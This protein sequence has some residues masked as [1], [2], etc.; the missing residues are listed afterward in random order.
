MEE[1]LIECG[2]CDQQKRRDSNLSSSFLH[3][4]R[5]TFKTRC[6]E[7]WL[8]F[9]LI[10]ITIS[11]VN[12]F[13]YEGDNFRRS[14]RGTRHR[15]ST[16][17]RNF[18]NSLKRSRAEY[19]SCLQGGE[20]LKGFTLEGGTKAGNFTSLGEA[21]SLAECARICCRRPGCPQALLLTQP[22]TNSKTCFEV[23]C[24]ENK[25]CKEVSALDSA[26][27]PELFR[28]G[29]SGNHH[30]KVATSDAE[31]HSIITNQGKGF[32][33]KF[34]GSVCQNHV[35]PNQ[36]YF[37]TSTNSSKLDKR[38]EHPIK[39]L[40]TRLTGKCRTIALQAICYRFFPQCQNSSP[41]KP[42]NICED[43]CNSIL[44]GDCADAFDDAHLTKYLQRVV[45]NCLRGDDYDEDY[46]EDEDEMNDIDDTKKKCIRLVDVL[47]RANT[48]EETKDADDSETQP[49]V[50][51]PTT[52]EFVTTTAATSKLIVTTPQTTITIAPTASGKKNNDTVNSL[53]E[54]NSTVDIESETHSPNKP[55]ATIVNVTSTNENEVDLEEVS[56]FKKELTTLAPTAIKT[57]STTGL[58]KGSDEIRVSAGDNSVLTLPENKITLYSST[59]PKEKEAGAYKYRWTQIS[60]PPNS[61]GE[62]EGKSTES[63]KLT[64]LD[65]P[66]LY[67]FKLEVTSKSDGKHGVDFV[68]I[69]VKQASRKNKPPRAEI[70]PKEQQITLPTNT[71]IL[72]GSKST[73]DDEIVTYKWEELKGPIKENTLLTASDKKILELKNLVAGVYKFKL[74]VTDSSGETDSTEASVTVK[75]EQDYPPEANAGNDIVIRLPNNSVTL[76]G[77]KSKDDKGFLTYAWR[78]TAESPICDLLGT[79]KAKLQVSLMTVGTYVFVLKVTD[80]SG[81]SNE[82]QVKVVVL[83]EENTVPIAVAGD[84]KE[85]VYPDDSTTLDGSKS[86]DNSKIVSYL[87]EK[88]SGPEKIKMV[89]AGNAKVHLTDLVPGTYVMKLTVTDDK[90]LTGSD[91][92]K[93]LVKK[94][95][96]DSPVADAGKDQ[97]L[98]LPART[99]TIDGGKSHDDGLIDSYVWTRAGLSPAAGE[100]VNGSDHKSMLQ[101]TGL[102]KGQ[103]TFQLTVTDDKGLTGNDEVTLIVKENP[104]S[105]NLVEMYLDID[106]NKFTEEDKK[107]LLRKISVLMEVAQEFVVVQQISDVGYKKGVI[108]VFYV[109]D[110]NVEDRRL[111]GKYVADTLKH[112]VGDGGKLFDITMLRVEPYVCRNKCSGHGFCDQSSKQCVCDAFWTQNILKSHFGNKIS[113]CDWSILYMSVI[114]FGIVIIFIAMAWLVCFCVAR[115]KRNI[116]RAR[117]RALRSTD[118]DGAEDEMLMIPKGLKQKYSANSLTFTESDDDSDDMTVFDKK[119]RTRNGN[120]HKYMERAF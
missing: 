87:W 113:N 3:N 17:S 77:S 112:K 36:L 20:Y 25:S 52:V 107:Q 21:N 78:K 13:I 91:T 32:C 106:I 114:V 82:A 9:I 88:I 23:K 120:I 72:D 115:K 5:K 11:Q 53:S 7:L 51:S 98:Y 47:P 70:F 38:L 8:Y 67:T 83:P 94:N 76:D 79:S 22:G 33:R 75:K 110:P 66:G 119:Q 1:E 28:K 63:V 14:S 81:Q 16:R 96:N 64:K 68:N 35:D 50:P 39:L 62:I 61:H 111:D 31:S 4:N 65:F 103:Y 45:P 6:T 100:V 97:V 26:Y 27:K 117:Y 105:L 40:S 90:K 48:N 57:I 92:V 109:R 18:L 19:H 59:W 84:D 41:P 37:Y 44:T 80:L 46:D 24:H 102:V 42:V 34:S 58:P 74:T 54:T 73:D 55:S 49:T 60:A 43:E 12:S 10:N 29:I 71:I 104:F 69:T 2:C 99:I 86:T 89:G 15:T 95:H 101:L 56:S 118:P 116:R 85:I 108:V 93:V 30:R